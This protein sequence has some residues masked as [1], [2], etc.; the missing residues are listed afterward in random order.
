MT[1]VCKLPYFTI[2][3]VHKMQQDKGAPKVLKV[4]TPHDL[5]THPVILHPSAT[6]AADSSHIVGSP[7]ELHPGLTDEKY[8]KLRRD[9]VFLYREALVSE[10]AFLYYTQVPPPAPRPLHFA[11]PSRLPAAPR[12]EGASRPGQP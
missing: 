9:P 3:K 7:Q 5:H 2:V 11:L 10:N 1:A 4:K 6:I 8:A 12:S